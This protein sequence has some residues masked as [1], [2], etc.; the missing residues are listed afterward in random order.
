MTKVKVGA[1][2]KKYFFLLSLCVC[3]AACRTYIHVL[4]IPMFV[5]MYVALCIQHEGISSSSTDADIFL[6]LLRN[7]KKK[8]LKIF[9][10]LFLVLS[11][12]LAHFF[13]HHNFFLQPKNIYFFFMLVFPKRCYLCAPCD[14]TD[15]VL[16]S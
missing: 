2:K 1:Q 14:N 13:T 7:A 8:F 12:S 3:C 9:F 11:F 16:L 10:F 15:D 5:C 4:S 6:C